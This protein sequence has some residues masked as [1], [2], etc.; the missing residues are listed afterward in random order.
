M[1]SRVLVGV[2]GRPGG[3]DAPGGGLHQLVE[4]ANADLVAGDSTMVT[5]L[6]DETRDRVASLGTLELHAAA[7]GAAEQL[8]LWSESL[9]LLVV[10]SRGFGPLGRLVHGSTSRG[11]T[12]AARCPLLVMTRAHQGTVQPREPA[13]DRRRRR[14]L[15]GDRRRRDRAEPVRAN[16]D[17]AEAPT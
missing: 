17:G 5:R 4:T 9:D 2:D 10:G 15:A 1:F 3:R 16:P 14:H 12:R 6:V 13:S 11:L 8:A 7:G